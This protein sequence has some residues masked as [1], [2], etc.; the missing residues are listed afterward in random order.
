MKHYCEQRS[1]EWF[2][3]RL[4]RVTSTRMKTVAHG[5]LAAQAKLL[6]QM[7]YEVDCPVA[8]LAQQMEGFGYRTP[9]AIKLGREREDWMLARYELRRQKDFGRRIKLDRPGLMVHDSIDLFASSP[10]WCLDDRAGEGKIRV[11]QGKHEFVLKRG[12][13]LPEDK[14]QV[15]CHMMTGGFTKA[16]FASYCPDWPIEETRLAVIEVELDVP[17]ANMLYVKLNIFLT[18]FRDGTRPVARKKQSGVP[19][20][21]DDEE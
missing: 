13:L 16:D 14:D 6:D 2:G 21:F 12:V 20:F 18:H 9:A 5:T 15:Y 8:A 7:Q 10:D 11:D 3:L 4:G 19:S 17:Y 1:K